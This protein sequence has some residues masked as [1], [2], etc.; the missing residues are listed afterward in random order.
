MAPRGRATQI[1]KFSQ[2]FFFREI[3][4]LRSFT[5]IKFLRNGETPPPFADVGKSC[6][7]LTLQNMSFNVFPKI[8]S[9]EN[10]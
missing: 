3:S 8:N 9:R 2:G 10:L 1:Q 7:F 5:E 6:E 4:H